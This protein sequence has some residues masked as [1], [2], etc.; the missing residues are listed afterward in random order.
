MHS[1]TKHCLILS[2]LWLLSSCITPFEPE[3]KEAKQSYLVVDGFINSNGITTIAL[4]RTLALKAPAANPEAKATLFIEQEAGPRYAL[5]E[6]KTGT[7]TSQPLTLSPTARYRLAIRTSTGQDYASGF[8][9]AQFTPA[10]DSISWRASDKG[11]QLYMN[12]HDDN[13]RARHFRWEY[14]ETWEFT[15]VEFSMLVYT[16]AMLD[17]RKDDIYHCWRSENSTAIRV[18]NTVSLNQNIISQFPLSLLP[19]NSQKLRYKYSILVRQYALTPEEFAY[20]D[21]LR[22][23]TET[24]GTLF[25]PLPSQLTGNVQNVT[26][27]QDLALGFVGVHS[28]TSQRIFIERGQLPRVWRPLTGYEDCTRI[29]TLTRGTPGFGLPG[30]PVAFFNT[31]LY[32][33]INEIY[34]GTGVFFGYTYST[35]DCVDCRKR[36]TSVRPSYWQ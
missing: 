32:T 34:K 21:L 12:T 3:V 13:S 19:P 30:K 1:L 5:R 2:L 25:D 6:T 4:S 28:E 8:I 27:S 22:K 29:D 14:E 16:P 7:Y 36:G 24:L 23:N 11:L 9:A 33:P 17:L 31:P 20:W 35:T 26:D 15:S 18:S 10:I